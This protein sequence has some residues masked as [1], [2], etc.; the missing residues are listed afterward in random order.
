MQPKLLKNKNYFYMGSF[1]A[2]P[3][4]QVVFICVKFVTMQKGRKVEMSGLAFGY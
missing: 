2:Y 1:S 3:G 4:Q